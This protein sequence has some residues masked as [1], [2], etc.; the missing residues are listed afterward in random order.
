MA[1]HDSMGEKYPNVKQP[2]T[3]A[4]WDAFFVAL[5]IVEPERVRYYDRS[6]VSFNCDFNWPA[7][8]VEIRA[9]HD[10]IARRRSLYAYRGVFADDVCA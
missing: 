4:E 7:T 2:V 1:W 3:P 6:A 9:W 10:A 5:A 8:D